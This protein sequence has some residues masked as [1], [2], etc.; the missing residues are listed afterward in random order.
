[1]EMD[2]DAQRENPAQ[3]VEAVIRDFIDK[4]PENTLKNRENDRAWADP[5][6]GF[7]RGHDPIYGEFREMIGDFGL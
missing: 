5:L 7:S 2:T 1:M 6:V 4:A 3:W